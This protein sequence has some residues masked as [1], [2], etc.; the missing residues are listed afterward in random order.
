MGHLL[1]NSLQPAEV[2]LSSIQTDFFLPG[3]AL[4][5]MHVCHALD[6]GFPNPFVHLIFIL[7]EPITAEDIATSKRWWCDCTEVFLCVRIIWSQHIPP[8]HFQHIVG[9]MRPVGAGLMKELTQI[10]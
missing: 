7:I 10:L 1:V 9:I 5:F 6:D 8:G 2:P 4:D 3:I